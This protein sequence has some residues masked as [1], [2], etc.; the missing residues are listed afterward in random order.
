MSAT[1]G[2][3]PVQQ[4]EF[5]LTLSCPDRIGIVHAVASLLQQKQL[6]ILD[7]AQFGDPQTGLFCM[8]IHFRPE[9]G[10]AQLATIAKAFEPIAGQFQ[11]QWTLA[12]GAARRRVIIM[13]SKRD[14][15]LND[16]LYRHRTG[17]LPMDLCA[18]ISNHRDCAP[19]VESHGIEFFHIPRNADNRDSADAELSRLLE[20]L[21]PELIVL[22]RYMQILPPQLCQRWQGK[23]IN[24][25]HSFLPGFKGARPYERAY[26]RG[27][28]LIGATAHYVTADL[29]EGPIIDQGVERVDHS[30]TAAELRAVGQDIEQIVL[31]RA[32]RWHLAHRI[33]VNGN[34][35]VVFR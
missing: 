16:L 12:D 2:E 21:E 15:C 20:G 26:E 14:H 18:V 8:R 30:M 4:P 10:T 7:S 3:S 5:V 31:A 28:K 22:A 34:K 25:H 9:D 27:V 29:D 35:T 13:V 24:I 17:A 32:V 19:L 23:I 11:M 6:T 1:A 33:I